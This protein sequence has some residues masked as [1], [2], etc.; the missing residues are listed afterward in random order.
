MPAHRTDGVLRL[1]TADGRLH[2]SPGHRRLGFEFSALSFAAPEN[3]QFRYHLEGFDKDW[4]EA[5]IRR[6]PPYPPRS[7]GNY[8]R[9]VYGEV[10]SGH[11][12]AEIGALGCL[13]ASVTDPF[14]FAAAARVK[15]F[16]LT[17]VCILQIE[18]AVSSEEPITIVHVQ[19]SLRLA[20]TS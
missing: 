13:V 4:V 11:R 3:V 20:D 16:L 12:D 1:G 8:L 19:L 15:A 6:T 18:D 5:S 10:G 17:R 2:W 7:P 14:R 9:I